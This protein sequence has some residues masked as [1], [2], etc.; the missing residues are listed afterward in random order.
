M[1]SQEEPRPDILVGTVI[2]MVNAGTQPLNVSHSEM[3]PLLHAST[4]SRID[5]FS[6]LCC[7]AYY[8]LSAK[9][10]FALYA[11]LFHAFP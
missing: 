7:Y 8:H 11:V 5:V 2:D 1:V 4:T 10:I 3:L 6:Q 9:D